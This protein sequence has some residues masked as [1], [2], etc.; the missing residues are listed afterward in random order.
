MVTNYY[1]AVTSAPAATLTVLPPRAPAATNV[2]LSEFMASNTRT[3]ADEDGDY[4]DWIEVYNAGTNLVNLLNWSLT[5]NAGNRTK[6]RFPATNLA[7]GQV[8]VVFA[9]NKNRRVAGA[10]LHTNFKLDANPPEYLALVRPDGSIATEFRPAFPTQVPDVSFGFGTEVAETVVLA[11]NATVRYYIPS[12]STFDATWMQPAFD[13]AAWVTG[14]QGL[15]FN[16]GTPQLVGLTS[17]VAQ[18][19]FDAPPASPVVYDSSTNSHAGAGNSVTWKASVAGRAGVMDFNATAPSQ[20]E[21]CCPIEGSKGYYG[22]YLTSDGGTMSYR[23]RIR[24]GSF[25]HLQMVPLI[26][27]GHLVADMLAIVAGVDF[28]LADLDR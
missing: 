4:S 26:S 9:S 19:K 17:L 2:I 5:D 23:T 20:I 1:G 18:L 10:P 28:V 15:G 27:R 13:D 6:W 25:A 16:R 8:L 24:T 21:A 11:S 14:A 3:L 7:P 12:N 22:Y